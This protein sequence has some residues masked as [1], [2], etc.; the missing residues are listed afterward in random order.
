[1]LILGRNIGWRCKY[2]V[3]CCN[4]DLTFDLAVVTLTFKLNVGY[5]SE[6][7]AFRRLILGCKIG[8]GCRCAMSK[9]DLDLT[10]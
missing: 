7:V 3:S 1:M 4:L 6:T 5:I 9:C 10:I 2:A 8:E